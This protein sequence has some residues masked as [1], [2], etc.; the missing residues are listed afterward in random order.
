MILLFLGTTGSGK[1]TQ[2]E[3]LAADYGF[4]VI[5]TGQLMRD[6]IARGTER[7]NQFHELMEKGEWLSDE[8]TYQLLHEYLKT[9]HTQNII[10]TGAVRRAGQIQLMDETLA[11]LG[12]KLDKVLYFEVDDVEVMQRL[13][14]RSREDD[15]EEAIKVRLQSNRDNIQPILEAYR[16]QGKLVVINASGTV[17]EI[18]ARVQTALN[19]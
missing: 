11:S 16:A 4:E 6:E 19:P 7:G 13:L 18:A 15:T 8:A 2:A 3:I 17:E 9:H 10:F 1:D 12:Q 5:S 14:K